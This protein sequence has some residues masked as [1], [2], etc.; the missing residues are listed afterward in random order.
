MQP[1]QFG[2]PAGE[3][4]LSQEGTFA[5]GANCMPFGSAV[6]CTAESVI[7][8]TPIIPYEV[9]VQVSLKLTDDAGPGAFVSMNVRLEQASISSYQSTG[10]DDDLVVVVVL[11]AGGKVEAVVTQFF[12][13]FLPPAETKFTLEARSV[14]RPTVFPTYLPIALQLAPGDLLRAEGDKLDDFVVIPPGGRAIHHLGPHEYNATSPGRHI[15][16][17]LGQGDINLRGP[18]STV[19]RPLLIQFAEGAPHAVSAAQPDASWGFNIE[20]VPLIVG[21]VIETQEAAAGLGVLSFHGDYEVAI[22]YGGAKVLTATESGCTP[23]CEFTF[24][25]DFRGTSYGTYLDERFG[26]GDY[27]ATVHFDTA[28]SIQVR[29]VYGYVTP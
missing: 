13:S 19:L 20:G 5:L 15:V 18:A 2:V 22:T 14:V 11:M 7:D 17:A 8:L 24:I 4:T 12:P 29:E 6:P 1:L 16:V 23:S 10:E 21:L 27:E 3:L 25:G 26:P 9:P 28:A